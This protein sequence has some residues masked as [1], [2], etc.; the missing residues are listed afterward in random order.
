MNTYNESQSKAGQWSPRDRCEKRPARKGM[1][2]VC[3]DNTPVLQNI[4]VGKLKI[5]M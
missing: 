1:R 3:K 4:L 2:A 5:E